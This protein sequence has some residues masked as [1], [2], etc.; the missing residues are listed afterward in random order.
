MRGGVMGGS[1]LE[2]GPER[3]EAGWPILSGA[4]SATFMKKVLKRHSLPEAITT[5]GLRSYSAVMK[6]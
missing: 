4:A 1:S 6:V 2:C 3:T 5:D